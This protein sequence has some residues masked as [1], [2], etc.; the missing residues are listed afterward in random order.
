MRF[1][2]YTGWLHGAHYMLLRISKG[3]QSIAEECRLDLI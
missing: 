3:N 2:L 1:S